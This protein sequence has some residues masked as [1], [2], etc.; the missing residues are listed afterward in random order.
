[1]MRVP[2]SPSSSLSRHL[3]WCG[4]SFD[5]SRNTACAAPRLRPGSAWPFRW[6]LREAG[7]SLPGVN[8]VLAA[9]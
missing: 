8:V 7:G 2:A 9:V 1:M 3:G 6:G 4:T 5:P